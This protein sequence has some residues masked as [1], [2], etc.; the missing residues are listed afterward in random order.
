MTGKFKVKQVNI[1]K[2]IATDT[3]DHHFVSLASENKM[4]INSVC[5]ST[6]HNAHIPVSRIAH[7]SCQV[8][9]RR[10]R[11]GSINV[12]QMKPFWKQFLQKI[13]DLFSLHSQ[14]E[15]VHSYP[16]S[17][18][19]LVVLFSSRCVKKGPINIFASMYESTLFSLFSEL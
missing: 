2:S 8:H 12:F 5:C 16:H 13:I 6:F 15:G 11:C 4:M 18:C 3:V 10:Y 14:W 7:S 17:N 9:H 1:V 19:S